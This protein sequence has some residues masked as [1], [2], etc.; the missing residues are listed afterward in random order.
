MTILISPTER[1]DHR[2][3]FPN[4]VIS[5]VPEQYGSD[6]LIVTIH[7][8]LGIQQ[9]VFPDDLFASLNDGRLSKELLQM[10]TLDIAV[11]L[12][13]GTPFYTSDGYLVDVQGSR[14]KDTAIHNF[15]RSLFIQHRVYTEWVKD[16][17]MA[18]NIIHEWLEYMSK[19]HRGI[20]TRPK[21][22]TNSWGKTSSRE[23]GLYLLQ[24]FPGIGPKRAGAI[25]DKFGKV[26]LRWECA[27]E[28]L[29][30]VEGIGKATA[31]RLVQALES[32]GG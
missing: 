7:G 2:T 1:W 31:Q 32:E 13:K 15:Q 18:V 11:L 12:L 4:A 6:I 28:E 16:D 19:A 21:P 5:S 26:P 25:F 23:W 27:A 24:S 3:A 29:T 14:W 20:S 30:E 8:R 22:E 10:Q 9:K 17:H